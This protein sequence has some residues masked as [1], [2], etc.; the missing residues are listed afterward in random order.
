MQ[1]N[2]DATT[3]LAS[4]SIDKDNGIAIYG[5]PLLLKKPMRSLSTAK[6]YF[7]HY[8]FK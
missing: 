1:K 4:E 3:N 7:C 2:Y 8:Y 5:R 6:K